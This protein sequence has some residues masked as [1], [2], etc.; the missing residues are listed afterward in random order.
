MSAL[1]GAPPRPAFRAWKRQSHLVCLLSVHCAAQSNGDGKKILNIR[2][3]DLERTLAN[4]SEFLNTDG[5][6]THDASVTSM[7]ITQPGVLDLDLVQTCM[8]RI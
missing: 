6:H 1:M 4:D 3:F 5:E 2:A 7:S 8:S